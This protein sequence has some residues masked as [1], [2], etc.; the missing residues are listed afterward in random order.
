MAQKPAR[1]PGTF[2]GTIKAGLDRDALA[3]KADVI[4][5]GEVEDVRDEA[6]VQYL[7][8]GEPL[9]FVRRIA[10]LRVDRVDKGRP[11]GPK[12]EVE[13]LASDVPSSLETVSRGERVTLFLKKKGD[14]Y[15]F[16]DVTT[17]KV[18]Y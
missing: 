1:F 4:A 10:T 16:A 8:H 12:I 15:E 11:T 6:R 14:R 7:V 2:P 17:S 13:F 5:A 9:D 18:P 3:S